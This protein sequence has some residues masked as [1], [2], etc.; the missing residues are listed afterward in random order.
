MATGSGLDAQ[1]GFAAESTVGTGVTVTKFVEF[2]KEGLQFDAG[3]LEPT[4][5]R[6]GRKFKRA[7]RVV[8]SRKSVSGDIELQVASRGMGLLWKHALGST[9]T[10]TVISGT[11]FRQV[12][13][14]VGMQGL[15]LTIQVGRPEPA[16]GTV[17]P[18]TFR[19]CKISDWEFSLSDGEVAKLKLSVDGW[20]ETLAT[21]LATSSYTSANLYSFSQAVLKLGG[22]ASTTTGLMSV[23]SGVQVATVIK[24]FSVKY[25]TPMAT[26]RYGVG[27][28]GVKSEQLENDF[29]GITGKFGAEFSK[30]ELYDVFKANTTLAMEFVM[31][32]AAI[33]ASGSNDTLSIICP[34]IKIKSAT[35]TVDGP[36]IVSMDVEW[37]AYDDE[38]NAPIQ[39]MVISADSTL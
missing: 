30:V 24:D 17:R 29:P 34:A 25:S 37:E 1:L 21:A 28:A 10:P 6:V 31:T 11:A 32:G 13:T 3:F 26:E 38:T 16:S 23:A 35:P 18:F 33:G 5:L 15:G 8:Q 14:P 39:V 36:D 2:D 4:G 7:S 19:G 22:T 9:A 12:H 20:D 27:N